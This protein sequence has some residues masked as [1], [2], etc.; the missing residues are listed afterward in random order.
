MN[1]RKT[2]FAPQN[3]SQSTDHRISICDIFDLTLPTYV[4]YN[5][6]MEPYYSS[7]AV[8]SFAYHQA[9]SKEP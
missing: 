3:D 4:I 2:Y 6:R 5:V 1:G 7:T 8:F 9:I